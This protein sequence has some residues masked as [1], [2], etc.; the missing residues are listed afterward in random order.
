MKRQPTEW[1]K[2]LANH[3]SDQGLIPKMCKELIKHNGK[4]MNNLI[5]DWA[6]DLKKTFSQKTYT[7]ANRHEKMLTIT[8]HQG[9][10]NQSHS[11]TSPQTCQNDYCQK[12]TGR[13]GGA[14]G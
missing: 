11:E 4:K 8:H 12:D 10:I 6:E 1:E 14:V 3:I 2:R 5:E 7:M 13:L 9:N